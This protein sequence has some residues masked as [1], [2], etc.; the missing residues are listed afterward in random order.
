MRKDK[1]ELRLHLDEDEARHCIR[2][3][4]DEVTWKGST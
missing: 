3:E 4:Q 1:D 2:E